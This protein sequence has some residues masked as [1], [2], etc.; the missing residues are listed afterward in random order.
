MVIA[1]A[2]AVA[3]EIS[4]VVIAAPMPYEIRFKTFLTW[5]GALLPHA[6]LW[7]ISFYSEYL[8]ASQCNNVEQRVA[9]IFCF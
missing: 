8:H 2:V 1:V 5:N 6:L 3:V 7:K 4:V 9:S